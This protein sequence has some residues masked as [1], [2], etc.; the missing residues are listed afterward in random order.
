[1]AGLWHDLVSL[2][3]S[4]MVFLSHETGS[5]GIGIIL[6]TVIIRLILF[7]LYKAQLDSFKRMQTMQPELKRIQERYKD[8][9]Q[10][11]AEE[12]M[13]LYREGG[14]NPLA[15]CLP[16]V[17]QLPLIYALYDMLRVFHFDTGGLSPGFLWLP[18]LR[19]VDPLHIMPLLGG[20]STYWQTKISMALQPGTQQQQ[21]QM[22]TYLMPVIMLYVFWKLPSGLAL[23]W[24]VANL[25]TIGQQYLTLGTLNKK[26]GPGGGNGVSRSGRP[27]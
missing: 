15:S 9:K 14:V 6:L 24:V 5:Y 20:L 26:D 19:A 23:Y 18:N 21:M 8:D 16:M 7:P 13:K 12:Q 17:L 2:M 11:L 1:M 22:M 25:M 4:S 27:K 3:Q 10:R